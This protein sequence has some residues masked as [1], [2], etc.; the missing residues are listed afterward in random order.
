VTDLPVL[1]VVVVA[2]GSPDLLD[3]CLDAVGNGLQVLVID[4]SSS[5]K[6]HHIAAEHGCRYVDPGSNLGFAAGVNRALVE[7]GPTHGDVL[8]LNPDAQL[9]GE[10]ASAM[11]AAM[12]AVGRE[13][14]ACVS[15]ALTRD[16]GSAEQVEWP[17]PTPGRAWLEAI[18]LGSLRQGHGF[19]IGAVLLLRSEA[20]DD[21]GALDERF[22]L[23]AEETDWQRRAANKGWAVHSCRDLTARH[24]GAGTSADDGRRQ[25]LFHA[26]V[27]RYIRKWYGNVGWQTFRVAVLFGA[28]IR[29]VV[30]NQRVS[31]RDRFVRYLRGPAR[32]AEASVF[33]RE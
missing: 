11:Q 29:C 22:F 31:H 33:D 17:F 27:E 1:N 16:D 2:Y 3:R 9:T 26:S 28:A 14:V 18:G 6:A 15:P 4:N 10:A 23:Y 7:L 12:R 21:V 32:C 13:R 24:S 20:I 30:S 8:L 5:E 25:A 19:L